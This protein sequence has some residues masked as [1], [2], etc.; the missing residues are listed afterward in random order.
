MNRVTYFR[1]VIKTI[2]KSRK[3][4][5]RPII[6]GKHRFSSSYRFS[7]SSSNLLNFSFFLFCDSVEKVLLLTRIQFGSVLV[8]SPK[9]VSVNRDFNSFEIFHRRAGFSLFVTNLYSDGKCFMKIFLSFE[10]VTE[11][12]R[13]Y[14]NLFISVR[15]SLSVSHFCFNLLENMIS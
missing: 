6:V 11:M 1:L 14:S 15:F 4:L 10:V 8:G 9:P 12:I 7:G 13:C 2:S 5:T 3:N